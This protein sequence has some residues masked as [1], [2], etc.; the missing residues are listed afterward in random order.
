[1]TELLKAV[2]ARGEKILLLKHAPYVDCFPDLWD[3]AGGKS[4]SSEHM[5]TCLEGTVLEQTNLTAKV[6]ALLGSYEVRTNADD[7]ETCRVSVFSTENYFGE[8]RMSAE[9]RDYRWLTKE[10]I[11]ALPDLAPYL[12]EVFRDHPELPMM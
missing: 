3:L 5:T 12:K 11:L 9:H 8:I 4:C 10:E 6:K 2:I 1:M 7:V